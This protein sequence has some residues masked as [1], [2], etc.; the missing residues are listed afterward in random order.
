MTAENGLPG[1]WAVKFSKSR[2]REYYY[3]PETKESQ[4]EVPADTDSEQLARHL[5]EHPVQV[6][7]LH[8]LIKHAGSRRPASHR[9][10]HITLDK[11]AAVAELEQYAERYRQ[12][13]RFEE[14]A[15]ERSDC[16]SYK[17]GGD[18]GTFGR[19]EMQP[20]F[21]KVAFALPVGGVSDVVESDSG[22]HL[23]KRV[24]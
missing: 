13:E 15:R 11:A 7:C 14:L 20:S 17:R 5:A 12:G 23:I 1:P 9:N 24:A 2:K 22:V 10:E 6:R 18:L 3:N 4:W 21:E 19:G 8:L 16:S